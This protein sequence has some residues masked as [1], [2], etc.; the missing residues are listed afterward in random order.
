MVTPINNAD[1][2][3]N[4]REISYGTRSSGSTKQFFNN[5]QIDV[6]KRM[7]EYMSSATPSV[8]EPSVSEL[9]KFKQKNT[10][11]ENKSEKYVT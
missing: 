8:F 6:F 9:L 4:Q 7:W 3:P 5:S 2:L 1:E 11:V 10:R